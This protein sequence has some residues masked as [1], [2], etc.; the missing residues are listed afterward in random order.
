M[1]QLKRGGS[2]KRSQLRKKGP[3]TT[4]WDDFR[5][6]KLLRERNDEGVIECQDWRIGL[7]RCG[8]S[9]PSP[10]LHHI[11]GR[12][13]APVLYFHHPN[14][15]WLVR[16]CHDAAHNNPRVSS[17]EAQDDEERQMEATPQR[18]ALLD[19]QRRPAQSNQGQ[20]GAK[21]LSNL[22]STDAKEL[23]RKGKS[24]I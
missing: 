14:L 13:A 12:E 23:A 17:T 20:L 22:Q 11:I 21:I 9:V 10:D 19:L 8:M 6:K 16:A 3:M 18:D 7:P 5:D 24:G 15:V 2:L 1:S 4:L